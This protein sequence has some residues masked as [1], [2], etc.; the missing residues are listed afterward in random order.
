L[1]NA[2]K[3][4]DLHIEKAKKRK[5]VG[6]PP[7]KKNDPLGDEINWEILLESI[8]KSTSE[9]IIISNDS[10]YLTEYE[11]RCYLNPLLYREVKEKN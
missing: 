11:K 2:K 7:G 10:D 1:D 9:L 4:T 3:L 8:D 5:V 6:N